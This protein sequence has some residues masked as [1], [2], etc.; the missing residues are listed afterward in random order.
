MSTKRTI[1]VQSTR[2][3]KLHNTEFEITYSSIS[4]TY[5]KPEAAVSF[6]QRDFYMSFINPGKKV[7]FENRLKQKLQ[8]IDP[9]QPQQDWIHNKVSI[10]M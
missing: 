4:Q 3:K 10:I 5:L 6:G 9:L 1:Y 8:Q 2:S 7:F